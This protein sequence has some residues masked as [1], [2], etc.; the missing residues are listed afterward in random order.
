VKV[1]IDTWAWLVLEDGKDPFHKATLD[2]FDRYGK[3]FGRVWTS[4]FV[5]DETFT[6]LYRRRPFSEAHRFA[7]GI[8]S[9]PFIKVER[10]TDARFRDAFALRKKY[11]D[12]S[13]V[14][15]T[16]LTSMAIMIELEINDVLTA[17]AH[18]AQVGLGFNALPDA[19]QANG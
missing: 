17:D 11:S 10:V 19:K 13:K 1:F 3:G 14:S 5:L 15:F 12:E 7:T 9:S 8:L 16:D 2:C 6:L 18:F 4:N